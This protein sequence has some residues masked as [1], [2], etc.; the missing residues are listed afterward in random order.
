MFRGV[1]IIPWSCI[2]LGNA[3]YEFL[4]VVREVKKD[5]NYRLI[6]GAYK[7]DEKA[8]L[9]ISRRLCRWYYLYG[10]ISMIPNILKSLN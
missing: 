10:I 5:R 3:I 9:S 8:T 4:T 2:G 1:E 7:E 6:T